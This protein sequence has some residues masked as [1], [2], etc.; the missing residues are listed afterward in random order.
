M[1]Y[2]DVHGPG[3]PLLPFGQFTLRRRKNRLHLIPPSKRPER[4][5]ANQNA[6]FYIERCVFG[7]SG[8]FVFP[9]RLQLGEAILSLLE[10]AG[11]VFLHELEGAFEAP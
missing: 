10:Q 3:H 5:E 7:R 1:V 8:F 9:F 6:P 4:C 2:A 11:G